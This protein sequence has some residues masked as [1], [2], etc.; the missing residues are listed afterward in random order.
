MKQV[1]MLGAVLVVAGMMPFCGVGE[2]VVGAED[3]ESY[4]SGPWSASEAPEANPG[5]WYNGDNASPL[6]ISIVDDG[7]ETNQELQADFNL[8]DTWQAGLTYELSC[9]GN[10]SIY[11]EDYSMDFYLH[12]APESLAILTNGNTL[13]MNLRDPDNSL[14]GSSYYVADYDPGYSNAVS[15]GTITIPLGSGGLASGTTVPMDGSVTNWQVGFRIDSSHSASNLPLTVVL[16]DMVVSYVEPPFLNTVWAPVGVTTNDPL[17]T[18]T[19][20]DGTL[21]VDSICLY[22][23]GSL[24]ASNQVAGGSSVNTISYSWTGAPG[25]VHEGMV[26]VTADSYAETNRWTFQIPAEALPPATNIL[27]LFSFNIEGSNPDDANL[28]PAPNDRHSVSNGFVAAAPSLGSNVWNN[29][30]FVNAWYIWNPWNHPLTDANGETNSQC[31][32]SIQVDNS[33][34]GAYINAPWTWNGEL[35]DFVSGTSTGDTMW[36]VWLGDAITDLDLYVDSLNPDAKY[37]LYMYFTSPNSANTNKTTYTV[38]EGTTAQPVASLTSSW[39]PLQMYG[40]TNFVA[41]T[42]YVVITSVAPTENG[43]ITVNVSGSNKAGICAMQI[44]MRDDGGPIGPVGPT[45]DP[46]IQSIELADGMVTLLWVSETNVSYS[47]LSSS[48]LSTTNWITLTNGIPGGGAETSASVP[49]VS[50]QEFFRIMGE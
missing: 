45:V 4:L 11:I 50:D 17:L 44:A 14:C 46:D 6:L 22:V 41:G 13:V 35:N 31:I 39:A 43:R 38:V 36:P 15:G 1:R 12:I 2:V 23:D 49:A 26:V 30:M 29:L 28:N 10:D 20:A 18:A 33:P 37:D 19:V 34:V 48:S 42:N 8:S 5:T 47:V 32:F 21:E 24:M 40:P 25:G 16:D 9:T 7:T 27:Q 3:F